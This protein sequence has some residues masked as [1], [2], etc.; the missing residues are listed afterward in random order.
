[1]DSFLSR[2]RCEQVVGGGGG[3]GVGLVFVLFV[4]FW[5]EWGSILLSFSGAVSSYVL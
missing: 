2:I 5:R 1:M 4:C 3:G